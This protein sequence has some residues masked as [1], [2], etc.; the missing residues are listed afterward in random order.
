MI[1]NRLKEA[2]GLYCLQMD[3][4]L[5][6]DL[7]SAVRQ[8]QLDWFPDEFGAAIRN[9]E[10]TPRRWEDLTDVIMDDDD[11]ALLDDYLRLVWSKAAHGQPYPGDSPPNVNQ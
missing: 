10:F 7:G 9:G 4:V 11:D 5:V 8:G 2:I 3:D 1:S 6:E